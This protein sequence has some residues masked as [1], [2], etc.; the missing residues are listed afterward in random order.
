MLKLVLMFNLVR[1]CQAREASADTDDLQRSSRIERLLLDR[2]PV[3]GL[4]FDI[5]GPIKSSL[6][7]DRHSILR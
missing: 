5:D 4:N 2:D 3:R 1:Q 6:R 7:V